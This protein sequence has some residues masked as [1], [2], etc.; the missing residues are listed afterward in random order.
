MKI[1]LSGGGTF[2][3]VSPLIALY[4]EISGKNPAEFVW[5][6][7]KNGQEREFV[8]NYGIDFYSI[9][10]GKLRRYFSWQ[11]F[12]DFFKIL[13]GF[14]QSVKFL[15]K[16]KPDL[17]ITAGGF[18]SVPLV[19]AAYFLKIPSLC[20][21]QDIR[22]G[23]A[24]KLMAPF[25]ETVTVTFEKSFSDFKEAVLTGN[26]VRKEILSGFK[27]KV[28]Q[29]LNLDPS[30]ALVLILGG[31]T[32]SAAINNLV[33]D[34]IADL[35]NFCQV[36]HITGK[37]KA[38][39]VF[40]RRYLQYEFVQ[41]GLNDM[42]AAA[43]LIVCR[44]SMSLLS[45]AAV[46]KKPCVVIPLPNSHQEENALYFH[47]NNAAVYLKEDELDKTAFV[48]ALERI[49]SDKSLLINLS[50]NVSKLMSAEGAK[51]LAEV[52]LKIIRT[53]KHGL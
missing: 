19:W 12:F 26:P 6:G 16:H 28:Y 25:A 18:V 53:K 44:A 14:F 45:E 7:T 40:S 15:K 4:Q 22:P 41:R 2:G 43:D 50:R 31:G 35:A 38:V 47:K 49:L 27:E 24:N 11:N 10:S 1:I 17:V 36:I 20:H 30:A 37:G 42:M 8:S 46:L 5:V 48:S 23:L 13:A 3:S 32:G 34:S 33:Y 29:D 51:N 52:A 21:Q 9:S 39:K